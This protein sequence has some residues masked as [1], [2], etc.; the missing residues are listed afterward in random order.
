VESY[1]PLTYISQIYLVDWDA[2]EDLLSKIDHHIP[3]VEIAVL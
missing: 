1:R 3:G 2:D